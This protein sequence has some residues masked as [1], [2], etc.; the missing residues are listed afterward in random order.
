MAN[1]HSDTTT[2][3]IRVRVAAQFLPDHSD[4]DTPSFVF[5]YRVILTNV[6]ERRA[7]LLSRHWII[8]DANN[9][10]REVRGPGVVG[11]HPD[12]EPGQSFEYF[13][14]CELATGW[15]TMEGSYLMQRE[16]GETFAAKIGRFFLAKNVAPLT[17][18]GV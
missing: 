14:R 9:E 11:Q 6:G 7:K 2:E 16:H 15:G 1:G 13:S 5:A 17:A 10:E 3:G 12:L 8:R 4:P 18:M